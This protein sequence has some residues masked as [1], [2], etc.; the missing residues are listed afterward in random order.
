MLQVSLDDPVDK[1][2]TPFEEAKPLPANFPLKKVVM[3]FL[4]DSVVPVIDDWG[5]CLGIVHREDCYEVVL[6]SSREHSAVACV[7]ES[8]FCFLPEIL[9]FSTLVIHRELQLQ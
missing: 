1:Y 4:K 2:M 8:H 5:S 3:R 6:L 7:S 9:F